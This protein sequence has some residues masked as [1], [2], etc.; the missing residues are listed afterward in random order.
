MKVLRELFWIV[1]GKRPAPRAVEVS[2]D[3]PF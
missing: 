1:F 3:I 2:D